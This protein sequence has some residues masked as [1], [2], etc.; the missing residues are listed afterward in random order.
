L[1]Y[2]PQK[3]ELLVIDY[4]HTLAPS[5]ASQVIRKSK[6]LSE[7]REGIRQIQRYLEF[8]QNNLQLLDSWI[9][10]VENKD[11]INGVLLFRW[12]M[13]M[14][15]EFDRQVSIVDWFSLENMLSKENNIS[16]KSLIN[17][18]RTR[19]DLPSSV[20]HLQRAPEEIE[21]DN[22]TYRR[23]ILAEV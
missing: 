23:M 9:G 12:P 13:P 16:I 14:H 3:K 1:L 6:T 11:K 2:D 22:W 4:K 19:P 18:I 17:W 7:S 15:L 21:V 8:F 10:E 20:R 5:G